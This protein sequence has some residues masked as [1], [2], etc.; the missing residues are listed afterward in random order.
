MNKNIK[1]HYEAFQ[2]LDRFFIEHPLIPANARA[3][4]VITILQ[5]VITTMQAAV[6]NQ[7]LG[8]GEYL[9]GTDDRRRLAKDL[10]G[11]VREIAGTAGVLDPDQHPGAAEQF[12]MPIS[13]SYEALLGTARGFV[14]AI[15]PIK[16]AFVERGL[17]ADFDEQ[18]ADKVATFESATTRKHDG[19]QEQKG[20]TVTLQ[21]ETRRGMAAVKEL[22]QIVS[23]LLK[24]TNPVLLEVWKAAKQLQRLPESEEETPQPLVTVAAAATKNQPLA[25]R[26]A[27]GGSLNGHEVEN[28]GVEPRVN[29]SAAVLV[30]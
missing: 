21:L 15:G 18:L 9:G 8:R 29:G 10:R 2:R 28:A 6:S 16:A 17:P 30:A 25:N 4:A 20:G 12:A 13:Q 1:R 14:T 19:R 22:D 3:T 7:M 11:A 26:D 23:N 5:G 27:S 24:R